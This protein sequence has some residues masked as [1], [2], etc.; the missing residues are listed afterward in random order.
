MQYVPIARL[1]WIGGGRVSFIV[2]E[3][4]PIDDRIA[5]ELLSESG[6]VEFIA[7][8]A[9]LLASAHLRSGG[10]KGSA[11]LDTLIA[12]GQSLNLGVRRRLLGAASRAA[13][14]QLRAWGEFK[15]SGH[16]KPSREG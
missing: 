1:S 13:T 14:L 12:Y 4:Q 9:R 2:H 10:W 16:G 5:V 7:Q 8:W 15:A 3:L 6:Y 11:D